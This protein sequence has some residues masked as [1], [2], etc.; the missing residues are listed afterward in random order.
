[1]KA[2]TSIA[3]TVVIAAS[4]TLGSHRAQAVINLDPGETTALPTKASIYNRARTAYY[5][6][7]TYRCGV[8]SNELYRRKGNAPYSRIQTLNCSSGT[9]AVTT[10]WWLDE[11]TPYCYRI[12]TK[13]LT[14]SYVWT[15]TRCNTTLW[16]RETFTSVSISQQLANDMVN[17][18]DWN[19]TD[20][21]PEWEYPGRPSLF[22]MSVLIS[23]P[24]QEWGLRQLERAGP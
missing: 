10:D 8:G 23:G 19:E 20:P 7:H 18:F 11:G 2:F 12:K 4:L 13:S 1:M 15:S 14:G 16:Y 6:Q 17:R 22:Y 9:Y 3:C 21:L 5:L 24:E